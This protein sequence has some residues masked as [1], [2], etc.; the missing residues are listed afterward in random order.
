MTTLTVEI[1]RFNPDAKIPEY[2]RPGDAGMDIVATSKK[3]VIEDGVMF[4]EYGTGLGFQIPDGY[5]GLI[6]PRSSLSKYDLLLSNHVGVID[7]NYRGEVTF[8]FKPIGEGKKVYNVGDRIGQILIQP[9]PKIKFVEVETLGETVRGA[10][11]Y[12]SSGV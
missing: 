1:K 3:L 11:G 4:I 5:V 12:G 10:N 7:S 6:K 2:S 9:V 8:R